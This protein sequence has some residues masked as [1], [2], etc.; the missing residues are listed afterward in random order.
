MNRILYN[1]DVQ[2]SVNKGKTRILTYTAQ[3][4]KRMGL[5]REYWGRV[6][7]PLGAHFNFETIETP[8]T[9]TPLAQIPN[10]KVQEV[11]AQLA[12]RGII[13]KCQCYYN[14]MQIAHYLKKMGIA[15]RCVEGY[16][17]AYG[18]WCKHRFNEIGG[19]YFDATAEY[20]ISMPIE[21]ILYCGERLYSVEELLGISAA[22]SALVNSTPYRVHVC[23]TLPYNP[24]YE[25]G[26]DNINAYC[27]NHEGVLCKNMIDFAA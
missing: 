2:V 9:I 6:L 21:K 16:Y 17:N 19:F 20:F 10:V 4:F 13:R 12:A 26:Y 8:I 3:R 24:S 7:S 11:V 25:G 18:W 15:V 22:M 23:S 5:P 14:C 27:L 1:N